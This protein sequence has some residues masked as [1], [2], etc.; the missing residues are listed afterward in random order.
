MT[1]KSKAGRP[2]VRPALLQRVRPSRPARLC[3]L[4]ASL[5]HLGARLGAR[6]DARVRLGLLGR[7]GGVLALGLAAGFG[8]GVCRGARALLDRRAVRDGFERRF[9][10]ERMANDYLTVYD[11]LLQSQAPAA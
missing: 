11:G 9:T 3:R 6:A 4:A 8:L 1:Y 2:G 5:L 10:V 7:L